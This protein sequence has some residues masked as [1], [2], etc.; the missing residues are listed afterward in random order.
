MNETA[1][2]M[3]LRPFI[4]H[5]GKAAFTADYTGDNLPDEFGPWVG[6]KIRNFWSDREG[7]GDII[8]TVQRDGFYLFDRAH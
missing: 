8:A 1:I 7:E 6:I 3:A 2:H 4:G 5:N